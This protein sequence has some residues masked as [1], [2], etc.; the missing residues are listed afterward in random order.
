M[1]KDIDKNR[2]PHKETNLSTA[3]LQS[4]V[5]LVLRW[6]RALWRASWS[7][8]GALSFNERPIRT[9]PSNAAWQQ[10]QQQ[11]WWL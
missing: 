8:C 11:E 10:T 5:H 7:D 2:R 3:L 6:T 4:D 1:N 9:T